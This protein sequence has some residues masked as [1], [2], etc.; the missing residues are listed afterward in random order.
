ML[1]DLHA[2]SAVSD[3][4]EPPEVLVAAAA[5]AG[6]DVLALTDHDTTA[7]WAAAARAARA[8]GVRLVP[9]AELTARVGSIRVHLLSYLHD[10][11]DL[12][13]REAVDGAR[14]TRVGR[15]RRM[16][17]LLAADHPLT[18]SDV[19][20]QVRDG[21]SVGRPHLADALV[22][23]GVVTSR[24]EAFATLLHEDSPYYVP[25][26]APRAEDLVR[27]VRAAGGVSVLAHP[28]AVGRGRVLDD[29]DIAALAAAGLGGLEV[30]HREHP[31]EIRE[32][33][34]ALAASLGLLV[35]G[36]SDHHG[37]RK[38]NLLG[39]NGTAPEVLAEIVAR[40]RGTAVIEG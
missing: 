17:E 26:A 34:R 27:L 1:I 25:H 19:Q 35:T 21:V 4:T 18:W 15:A 12:S 30:D 9:G 6:V 23:N 13:L 40:G 37:A 32:E 2:H 29:G 24:D 7:G 39:E 28:R 36:G 20:A 14:D 16:T 33:L 3:G 38:P 11:T 5:A 31:G 10:P 8:H 22:R